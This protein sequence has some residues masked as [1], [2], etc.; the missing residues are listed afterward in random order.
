MDF[1]IDFN[2]NFKLSYLTVWWYSEEIECKVQKLGSRDDSF[3]YL[4]SHF[5]WLSSL[6]SRMWR[7]HP[8]TE[9]WLVSLQSLSLN[10][11]SQ[12]GAID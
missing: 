3:I 10:I 2:L 8:L 12:V 1:L 9:F 5:I 7:N 11:L 4:T 6:I